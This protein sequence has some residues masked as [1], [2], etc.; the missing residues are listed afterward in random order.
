MLHGATALLVAVVSP[1]ETLLLV[2]LDDLVPFVNVP[3]ISF[4]GL[5]NTFKGGI[6]MQ[7]PRGV[8][9]SR[10]SNG[11]TGFGHSA[12]QNHT[13]NAV[14]L[15]FLLRERKRIKSEFQ[16]RKDME[17]DQLTASM[18]TST[19]GRMATVA[20]CNLVPMKCESLFC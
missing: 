4:G 2:G 14:L 3:T 11:R 1:L 18:A 9:E 5:G 7:T 15:D 8:F 20:T 13:R 19:R 17:N 12:F 16:E 6:E 10:E